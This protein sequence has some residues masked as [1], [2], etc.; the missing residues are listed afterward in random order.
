ME[1]F[2]E[3]GFKFDELEGEAVLEVKIE[4]FLGVDSDSEV[5]FEGDFKN[6][7]VAEEPFKEVIFKF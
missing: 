5:C 4:F 3:S 6:G 7:F 2:K 1:P